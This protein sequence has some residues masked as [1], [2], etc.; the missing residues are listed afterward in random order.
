MGDTSLPIGPRDTRSARSGR[1]NR[2]RVKARSKRQ[3]R[4][5]PDHSG[6]ISSRPA[7][8]VRSARESRSS[9]SQP[10]AAPSRP[11]I[12]PAL[13]TT[14]LR[15][16]RIVMLAF[17]VF[18]RKNS[19]GS[20][21]N[22]DRPHRQSLAPSHGAGDGA[23]GH[24][25]RGRRPGVVVARPRALA[26]AS[27]PCQ[28]RNDSAPVGA[29]RHQPRGVRISPPMDAAQPPTSRRCVAGSPPASRFRRWHQDPACCPD[30]RSGPAAPRCESPRR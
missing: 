8:T 25:H 2:T 16:H 26:P 21:R 30:W 18:L 27:P 1:V 4:P 10:S 5:P 14:T 3:I 28:H 19:P 9:P 17:I 6:P 20:N 15:S 11:R 23:T 29:A 22:Q 13:W 7:T 24:P 12:Y